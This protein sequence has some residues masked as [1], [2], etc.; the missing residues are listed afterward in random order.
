MPFIIQI[1]ADTPEDLQRQLKAL[2]TAFGGSAELA[3]SI[4][5]VAL[6]PDKTELVASVAPPKAEPEAKTTTPAPATTPASPP[7]PTAN[8]V[9]DMPPAEKRQKG[10]DMLMQA[11]NKDKSV[12]PEL[13]K[14]REKYGVKQYADIP[15]DRVQDFYTDALLIVNCTGETKAA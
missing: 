11:F 3:K 5:S 2:G 12:M 15:D 7:A 13:N 1:T 6:S 9:V 4:N 8:V 10:I 14:L